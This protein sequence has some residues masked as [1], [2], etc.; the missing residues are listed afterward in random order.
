MKRI[1]TL[2]TATAVIAAT[3]FFSAPAQAGGIK[4]TY[5]YNNHKTVHTQSLHSHKRASYGQNRYAINHAICKGYYTNQSYQYWV[6]GYW[7]QRWIDTSRWDVQGLNT[8]GQANHV[9]VTDG[10]NESYWVNG[11]WTT[12][13]NRVW[14][15]DGCHRCRMHH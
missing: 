13:Y 4:V 7:D 10:Y 6:E 3:T 8:N 9:W 11:Y 14:V 2:L 15:G 12:G 5:G 1:S